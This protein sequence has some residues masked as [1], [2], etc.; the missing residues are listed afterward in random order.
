MCE[1]PETAEQYGLDATYSPEDNKLRLY[2]AS[3][4]YQEDRDLHE[5]LK[6]AGFKWAKYQECYVA[7]K[8]TPEREDLLLEL[9]GEIGDEQYSAT[10]RSAD[11][12]ERFSGY[13]DKRSAEAHGHADDFDAGPTVF[14]NQNRARAARQA[15]R[16]DRHR[17]RAVCQWSKAEY[18]Q[19]R[20]AGVI[21]HAL[22]K[23]KPAVRRSRIKTLEADQRRHLKDIEQA[24]AEYDAWRRV[25]DMEGADELLPMADGYAVPAEMNK[26]QRIAYSLANNDHLRRFWHPTSEEANEEARRIWGHGFGAY[27]FLTDDEFIHKP[28]ERF[29][30]RRFAQLYLSKVTPPDSPDSWSQRWA[31]HHALRL[32]YERAMLENEGGAV[33]EVDMI[34][35]GFIGSHQIYKVNRSRATGRVVSVLIKGQWGYTNVNGKRAYVDHANAEGL[36]KLNIERLGEDVYRPPTPEE[37]EAFTAEQKAKKAKTKSTAPKLLNPT[38]EDAQ[39]LQAL[40]NARAKE[41]NPSANASEVLEMTQAAYSQVSKC[42]IFG[43]A[44]VTVDGIEIRYAHQK[45]GELAFKIRTKACGFS[46]STPDRVIFLTDKPQKPLPL[47]WEAIETP[48][49]A[50]PAI[51]KNGRIQATLFEMHT[52]H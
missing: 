15:A 29:T 52:A 43:T 9:A 40:W 21:S 32:E 27:D 26:A 2:S 14:G 31:A 50:Q 10:E 30:P 42:D 18:W 25:A 20:T 16:H 47:N 48:P 12:A 39:R 4:L 17:T 3:N 11:R 34:P 5:R 41:K 22:Y 13:R 1:L 6:A 8:W 19:Q 45:G 38:I 35:G 24:T 36:A 49:A 33:A 23:Q 51:D 46:L 28:F 7:P 44:G 37:L